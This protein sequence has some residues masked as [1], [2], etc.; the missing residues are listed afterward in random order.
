VLDS[1]LYDHLL[2]CAWLLKIFGYRLVTFVQAFPQT[3]QLTDFRLRVHRWVFCLFL[4]ASDLVVANSQYTRRVLK[5][6]YGLD[7]G[8]IAV[9]PPVGQDWSQW[10]PL[11]ASQPSEQPHIT[12]LNVAN[13]QPKKGQRI[14]VE[15]LD[16]LHQ[17]GHNAC[18]QIAGSVKDQVYYRDLKQIIHQ[19]GLTESIQFPGFL[20]GEALA[21]AYQRSTIFVHPSLWEELGLAVA[22]AQRWG[23][24]IVAS[25]VG[26]IPELVTD[27]V[28]GLLVPPGDAVALADAI[29]RLLTDDRLRERLAAEARERSLS[30]RSWDDV[31]AEFYDALLNLE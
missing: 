28:D 14:L 6:F 30:H 19:K 5:T 20:E 13:T 2:L 21:Q 11:P 23:L 18:V 4:S 29:E 7:S 16:I 10:G 24:P 17:R 9:I 25:N 8:M 27:E 1:H 22:E 3:D 26:G 12:I 31:G 15:A